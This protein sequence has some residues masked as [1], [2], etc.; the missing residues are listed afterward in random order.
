MSILSDKKRK[1]VEAII[2][3]HHLAFKVE[4]LGPTAV[5]KA[6][7][8]R[9][10]KKGLIKLPK[11]ARRGRGMVS[12][13]A[14][15]EVGS[16]ASK[17]GEE[18]V[19]K[20]SEDDFWEYISHA[21]PRMTELER[22]AIAAS[23]NRVGNLIVGLGDK[24]TDR[25]GAVL[26]EEDA[27]ARREIALTSVRREVAMA[28]AKRKTAQQL[29]TQLQRKLGDVRRDWL[30]VAHT[31]MHNVLEEGKTNALIN[32]SPSGSDPLVFKRTRPD[33]CRYCKVLYL[34]GKRPRVFR[35]SQL[36]GNGS[37]QGRKARRPTLTGPHAT[38]WLPVIGATHPWCQC[39][40]H[41]LPE[42]FDFDEDGAMVYKGVKKS[43]PEP[44][45]LELLNHVC[46]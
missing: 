36:S 33:A 14:A 17:A 28:V 26:H 5:S 31:E 16:L 27:K 34:D 2:A 38:E 10:Q 40:L 42:G 24:V 30:M 6:D 12:V 1:R 46:Q 35:L 4:V 18:A 25:F 41:E 44:P 11:K 13:P 32:R 23:R 39:T 3:D 19:E 20:M 22:E 21:P 37:N 7:L 43:E 9:L 8:K 15:H 29:A 45:S